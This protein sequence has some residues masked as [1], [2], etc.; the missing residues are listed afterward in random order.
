MERIPK[1]ARCKIMRTPTKGLKPAWQI[2]A[3]RTAPTTIRQAV[4]ALALLFPPKADIIFLHNDKQPVNLLLKRRLS[5]VDFSKVT[6]LSYYILF[7]SFDKNIWFSVEKKG[8]FHIGTGLSE[9]KKR[10][11]VLFSPVEIMLVPYGWRLVGTWREYGGSMDTAGKVHGE[12]LE[13]T[14]GALG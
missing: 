2:F 4:V 8:K 11:S 9:T 1:R 7:C 10:H 13:G 12:K 5:R 14:G 3:Y 6:T